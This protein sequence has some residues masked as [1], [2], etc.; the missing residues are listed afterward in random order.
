MQVLELNDLQLAWYGMAGAS[1]TSPGA[2]LIEDGN[3]LY[4]EAALNRARLAPRGFFDQYWQLLN[5]DSLPVTIPG[6]QNNADLVHQHLQALLAAA[7]ETGPATEVVCAVPGSMTND[8]LSLLLGI[9]LEANINIT[10]FVNS[11]LLYA[12]SEPLPREAWVVDIHNRRGILTRISNANGMLDTAETIELPQLSMSGLIDGWLDQLTDQFVARSRFDP[13]RVAE[14]EQQLFDQVRHW[15]PNGGAA[16]A[17]LSARIDHQGNNRAVDLSFEDVAERA[18]KRYRL[19]E[20]RLPQRATIVLT[21][22]AKNLPGFARHL[23]DQGHTVISVTPETLWH[24][25]QACGELQNPAAVEFLQSVASHTDALVTDSKSQIASHALLDDTAV[26][27]SQLA[28]SRAELAGNQNQGYQV[29]A[30][31]PEVRVNS[32]SGSPDDVLRPGDQLEIG[33]STYL[34][35]R[36]TDG[37]SA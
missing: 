30:G 4:G 7:G 2:A 25:A 27:L 37:P 13:L 17:P 16:Q 33:N 26:P 29:A 34:C 12:L 28:K 20:D 15:L 11:A 22:G 14:T 21:P 3:I 5:S 1:T 35:I 8:Q 10:T 19:A 32:K 23:S 36:V 9:A 24:N 18:L 31:S 6:A